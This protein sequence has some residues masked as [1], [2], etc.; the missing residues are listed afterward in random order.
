MLLSLYKDLQRGIYVSGPQN[1]A[2][3]ILPPFYA[4]DT[5]TVTYY[6][7]MPTGTPGTPYANVPVTALLLSFNYALNGSYVDL[8]NTDGFT[9]SGNGVT[10]SFTIPPNVTI[11]PPQAYQVATLQIRSRRLW[12]G[13]SAKLRRFCATHPSLSVRPPA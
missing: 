12:A 9:A 11:P 4:G 13:P 1:P 2:P 3:F 8:A 10:G 7:Q 5:V 6:A